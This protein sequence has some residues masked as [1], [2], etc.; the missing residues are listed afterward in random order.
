VTNG[1]LLF[2]NLV[3]T[4]LVPGTFGVYIPMAIARATG[5]KAAGFGFYWLVGFGLLMLGALIYLVC[6]MEFAVPGPRDPGPDRRAEAPR[7]ERPLSLRAGTR[8]M[9][10]CSPSSSASTFLSRSPELLGYAAL[11]ALVF[12]AFIRLYEEP[13]LGSLFGAEYE[14]YRS[15]GPTLG[16]SRADRFAPSVNPTDASSRL[17]AHVSRL[18]A[19]GW[20]GFQA[21]RSVAKRLVHLV[22]ATHQ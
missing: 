8:C 14:E 5:A 12:H 6:V 9:S 7:G 2:K 16:P 4:V 22:P 19:H 13:K 1:L 3:F 18:T 15:N 11:L 21:L 20:N 17:T 10:V